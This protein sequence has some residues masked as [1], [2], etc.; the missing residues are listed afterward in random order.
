MIVNWH[1]VSAAPRDGTPVIL[2]IDGDEALPH[3]ATTVGF[4]VT[5]HLAGISYWRTFETGAV[6]YPTLISASAVGHHFFGIMA[7]DP[8]R[9]LRMAVWLTS[10]N[11]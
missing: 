9:Y 8:R 11:R 2:W 1:P 5:N 6:G 4:W 3:T 10:R 7:P